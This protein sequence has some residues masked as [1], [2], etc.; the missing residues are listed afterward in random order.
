MPK[1][2]AAMP[3]IRPRGASRSMME[4]VRC[5]SGLPAKAGLRNIDSAIT[6]IATEKASNSCVPSTCLAILEPIIDPAKP[7]SAN[8]VAQGHFTLPPRQCPNRLNSAIAATAA[9]DVPMATC[10]SLTPTT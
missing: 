2:P 10:G 8:T 9:A 1:N 5:T 7:D 4:R 3:T 6:A